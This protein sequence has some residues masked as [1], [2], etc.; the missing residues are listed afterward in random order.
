[1]TTTTISSKGQ[2]IIPKQIRTAHAWHEG[3]KLLVTETA[4]GVLLRPASSFPVT[5][6]KDVAGCMKYRGSP[7]TLE[8]MDAAIAMGAR[9][10][11]K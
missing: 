2:V 10:N 3:Q 8:D 6:L 1:M 5:Q 7:K 4:D 11:L 9:E